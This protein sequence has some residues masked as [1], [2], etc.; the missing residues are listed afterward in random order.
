[1]GKYPEES[2]A[3]LAKI[4]AFTELH[5]ERA[6][7]SEDG[8]LLQRRDPLAGGDR[9][10]SLV[11][12]ALDTVPCEA[13]FVP[14]RRGDTARFISRRKAPVWVIAPGMDPVISQGLA[15]SYGV[16]PLDL[17]EEPADWCEF[18]VN[19]MR[20]NGLAGGRVTLVAGPSQRNPNANYRIEMLRTKL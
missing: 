14:T 17:A 8:N 4:A 15:F 11:E 2:V 18:A 13:V 16:H 9:I 3:M 7:R 19:W 10:A 1:M 12:H 6:T 5:R 20:E